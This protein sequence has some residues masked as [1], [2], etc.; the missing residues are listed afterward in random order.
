M[1]SFENADIEIK[2]IIS[3]YAGNLRV[4]A[5]KKILD[6]EGI[7]RTERAHYSQEDHEI[8]MDEGKDMEEYIMT[9]RHEYGHF[10]DEQL[11]RPS[12]QENFDMA[13]QADFSWY[14]RN[15]DYGTK[16]LENLLTN[17]E[18]SDAFDSRYF[19]DILSGVFHND[20]VIREFY[21][22]SGVAFYGHT[23]YYWLGLEGP[24]KAVQREVFANLFAI[25]TENDREI[26]SFVEKSFPN[27]IKEFRRALGGANA[28]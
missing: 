12:L 13:I 8:R 11:G 26:V 22:R 3:E 1:E 14:D 6:A 23:N 9:F 18:N 16:N 4:A 24:E 7:Y 20:R 27:T 5:C 10:A 2:N 17:L 15:T 19:S 21:D 28:K 25:Y